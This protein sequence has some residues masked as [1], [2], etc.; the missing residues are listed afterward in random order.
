[1][2]EKDV[3]YSRMDHLMST[4][5]INQ[6]NYLD[7]CCFKVDLNLIYSVEASSYDN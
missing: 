6:K 2:N 5:N 4:V 1:M 7:K 3:D